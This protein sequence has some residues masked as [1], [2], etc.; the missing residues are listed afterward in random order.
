MHSALAEV[1]KYRTKP[2]ASCVR[3]QNTVL[4]CI[5]AERFNVA[6]VLLVLAA[7]CLLENITLSLPHPV[8]LILGLE[9]AVIVQ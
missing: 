4:L 2:I 3:I 6:E 9:D 1:N 7:S 5:L 8:R